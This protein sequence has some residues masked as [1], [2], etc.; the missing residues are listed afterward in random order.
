MRQYTYGIIPLYLALILCFFIQSV[1]A[2][3]VPTNPNVSLNITGTTVDISWSADNADTYILYAAPYPDASVIYDFDMGNQTSASFDLPAGSAYYVAVR[4]SNSSG[5]SDW[6]NIEY[7][8]LSQNTPANSSYFNKVTNNPGGWRISKIEYD[9]DNDGKIDYV[10]N[11]TYNVDGNYIRHDEMKWDNR[12]SYYTYN[13]IGKKIKKEIDDGGDGI[14][15]EVIYY[16]Y[17]QNGN[18]IETYTESFVDGY[19]DIKTYFKCDT[20][21][22]YYKVSAYLITNIT[23][24]PNQQTNYYYDLK[25]YSND[26][27]NKPIKIETDYNGDG[28]INTVE[29][30]TYDKNG[31]MIKKEVVSDYYTDVGNYTYNQQGHMIS[32]QYQDGFAGI[33]SY[34]TSPQNLLDI[35]TVYVLL[36]KEPWDRWKLFTQKFRWYSK[37]EFDTNGD[38]LIDS[39]NYQKFNSNNLLSS[40]EKDENNDGTIDAVEYFTWIN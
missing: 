22:N 32:F 36:I 24:L 21:G 18:I 19:T 27:N 20:Y 14:I 23:Q 7:F 5:M 3:T 17:D 1:S 28:Q 35:E 38:G 25:T 26:A 37:A 29:Y 10:E 6:S 30:M 15:D 12:I 2:Q 31:N 11:H 34:D 13:N 8:D 9:D 40:V 39:I 16:T 4:A 33:F